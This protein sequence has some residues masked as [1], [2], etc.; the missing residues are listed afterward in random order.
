MR[1]GPVGLYFCSRMDR[2]LVNTT[3]DR[4]VGDISELGIVIKPQ[5]H[6]CGNGHVYGYCVSYGL[7]NIENE[8]GGFQQG[9]TA[10]GFINRFSGTTKI[11]VDA[12][13]AKLGSSFRVCSH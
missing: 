9:C 7:A 11:E 2:Q 12:R 6:L 8:L 5:S 4:I 3:L 1:R 13:R 10:V